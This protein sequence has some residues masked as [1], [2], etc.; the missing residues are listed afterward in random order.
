MDPELAEM[1]LLWQGNSYFLWDKIIA[2]YN[3]LPQALQKVWIKCT[4]ESY[5]KSTQ[6]DK[7]IGNA[8]S[9]LMSSLVRE[10]NESG[11][12]CSL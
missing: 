12:Y 1:G 5:N 3:A 6:T 10:K 4:Q 11:H 9:I 8:N 7:L 2:E